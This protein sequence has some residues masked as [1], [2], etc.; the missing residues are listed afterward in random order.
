M[1]NLIT[2]II[3]LL[4][5]GCGKQEQADTNESTPTTN[6]NEVDGTI[7]KPVKELTPEEKEV[8]GTYEFE[9]DGS[10]DTVRSVFLENG[11]H[12]RFVRARGENGKKYE[13][14]K[15]S[16][17]NREI[18]VEERDGSIR[19]YRII[20]DKSISLTV[21]L[22]LCLIV[23]VLSSLAGPYAVILGSF[24]ISSTLLIYVEIFANL[25]SLEII[26]NPFL[27]YILQHIETL[28]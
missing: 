11:V 20:K 24:F 12:M 6:T 17:S 15:W 2:L 1:K 26:K 16:I 3:G 10:D 5:A 19:V 22:R 13:G 25:P 8:V 9:I 23:L 7:V 18:H 28:D 27:P 14:T 4:V 21:Y